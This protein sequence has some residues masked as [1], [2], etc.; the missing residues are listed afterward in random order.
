MHIA[1]NG[2]F[3]DQQNTGS[4]QYVRQVLHHLRRV[5]PD[6]QMTL[7]LPPHNRAP[8]DLPKDVSI[9]TTGSGGVRPGGLRENL[10]KIWF[11][12]RTFPQMAA[13]VGADIAHVPYWG[14]PL[15]S[16]VR[17]VV[18][19]LDVIP[20]V[21]PE[22]ASGFGPRLYTSLVSA[23]ARGAAHVITLSEASKTDIIRELGLPAEMITAT[24]LAAD[25][26]YHPKIGAERDAA[27]REKYHLPERFV[28]CL[29]GFD[30]RKQVNELLL[31]YTFVAQSEGDAVPLVIAG[32][33][34]AWG[35][36]MFP[37]MRQYAAELELN[38]AIQWIGYV[39]D[40]DKPSLYRLA[41]VFV[42]PSR[43][44]G[45]GLPVLEAMASGTP[46]VA[47]EVSSIPEV[48]GDAA[49]LVKPGSQMDMARIMGG[50]IIA[51]LLQDQFRQ[52]QISR[53]L[54][55]ATN[56]SWRKTARETLAVYDKV[57][58]M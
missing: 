41:E 18:S 13:R 39:D 1:Y 37:D 34:P 26:S 56:F 58:Q 40:A 52:T 55:Q 42:F 12:Q 15:T 7:V 20:L 32:R 28:L 51:L 45:F 35:T 53:G 54:A 49:F 14:P 6:L 19:I 29:S 44:E 24:Y 57:M 9:V 22:Y 25:E 3:W 46:V 8:E 4:G 21:I 31:A 10:G 43:Y 50:A 30:V 11:E 17:L 27:V 16:S 36:P 48:A 23:A 5:A 47:N 38:D 33:E 2:W